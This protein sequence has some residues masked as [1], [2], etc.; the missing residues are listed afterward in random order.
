MIG[1]YYGYISLIDEAIGRILKTLEDAGELDSTLIVFSA[2]HGS[3]VGS[4]NFWDKGFGMYDVITRIPMIISHSSIKPG[5]SDAFVTLLDLAPTFFEIGNSE[6]PA[7]VDGRSLT[8]IINGSQNQIRED[9]IITEH[10][11]HQVVFWQR[12]VRT[13]EFKYI[14]NPTSNDE[15]YDLDSDPYEITN[16]IDNVDRKNLIGR[17]KRFYNGCKI[18]MIRSIGG[19]NRCFDIFGNYIG[20]Q[21]LLFF[22]MYIDF[23]CKEKL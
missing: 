20:V 2:D 17:E 15:F 4:Y 23:L 1:E 11:G 5:E 21:S 3:S 13:Q 14:Y 16:I 10:F 6:I 22:E 19:R 8:P 12:M 7:D 18:R 9:Y